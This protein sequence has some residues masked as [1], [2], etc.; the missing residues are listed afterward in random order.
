MGARRRDRT[1]PHGLGDPGDRR[2]A[3]DALVGARL[4][5]AAHDERG[6]R[7]DGRERRPRGP[8][9]QHLPVGAE[10]VDR[11]GTA[12]EAEGEQR[13]DDHGDRQTDEDTGGERRAR[14]R[15]ARRAGVPPVVR[16]IAASTW[17]SS[18]RGA[19][20]LPTAWPMASSAD[21]SHHPAAMSRPLRC[22]S[23]ARWAP[24][25]SVPVVSTS[26]RS[27]RGDSSEI[28]LGA[29]AGSCRSEPQ[30]GADLGGVGQRSTA[31]VGAGHRERRRSTD[32]RRGRTAAG[33]CRPPRRRRARTRSKDSTDT[34]P[35]TGAASRS[36]TRTR[37]PPVR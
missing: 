36:R 37:R 8:G 23:T 13:R 26:P 18:R 7:P 19:R 4:G 12:G 20:C 22:S 10:P 14:R 31:E 25:T 1:Q 3:R 28:T 9:Q 27:T 11:I 17:E 2:R 15:G 32:R 34:R 16:P 5:P 33:R 29:S 21:G 24:S 35:S 6:A 30:D